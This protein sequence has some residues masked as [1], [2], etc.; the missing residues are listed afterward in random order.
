[1]G[2]HVEVEDDFMSDV[3]RVYGDLEND[4]WDDLELEFV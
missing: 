1:M 4:G 2:D 3:A